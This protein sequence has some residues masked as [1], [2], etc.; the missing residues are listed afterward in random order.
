MIQGEL[1]RMFGRTGLAATVAV[2]GLLGIVASGP[3][4][5]DSW[6]P[7]AT[8]VY[9]AKDKRSR[10]TVTPRD[11]SSPLDYFEDKVKGNEPA[12]QRPGSAQAFASG[13]LERQGADGRWAIVWTRRLVNEVAPVSALVASGGFYAVTFDNWHSTGYGDNVVV[14]YGPLGELVRSLKL[15]DFLPDYYVEALP[16]SVSSMHWGGEH[17]IS[18]ADGMLVLRIVVP[19]Q[20]ADRDGSFVER[21]ILLATGQVQE[22]G[23][24]AWQQALAEAARVA[25]ADRAAEAAE[26]AAFRAPLLGPA[27][28]DTAAWHGY[29]REAFYRL[30]PDW[31]EASTATSVLRAPDAKDYLPT[32]NGLRH[33]LFDKGRKNVAIASPASPENLTR[34]L[35]DIVRGS[36]PGFLRG[37]RVYVAVPIGYRQRIADALGPSAAT[38]IHIDPAI[39]IPQRPERIEQRFGSR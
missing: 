21:R 33:W 30:A 18:D 28:D 10:L 27:T 26:H 22:T 31:R 36:S 6:M 12:G 35:T 9:Y 25:R 11:I 32:L 16:R 39:P 15:S 34:V 29:L 24:P 5:A 8:A 4:M 7:P 19:S 3:A 20:G 17:F 2:L 38:F 13:V 1:L 37:V 23:D 14:I